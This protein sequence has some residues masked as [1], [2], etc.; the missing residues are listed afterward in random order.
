VPDLLEMHN[1]RDEHKVVESYADELALIDAL[2][3][4][5]VGWNADVDPDDPPE[6]AYELLRVLDDA[7]SVGLACIEISGWWMV[8]SSRGP[9]GHIA[10]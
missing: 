8:A 9:T 7:A 5:G 2:V 6:R 3:G 4:V 10:A 1:S